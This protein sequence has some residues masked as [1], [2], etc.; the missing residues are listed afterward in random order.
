[1]MI[2]WVKADTPF[3][4]SP[5]RRMPITKEPISVPETVP[6][7][8]LERGAADDGGGKWH[9]AHI[10]PSLGWAADEAR[11]ISTQPVRPA[12]APEAM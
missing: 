12:S 6:T 3:M 4:F 7:P 8:P 10:T 11:D 1:M 9:P 5:L 2:C